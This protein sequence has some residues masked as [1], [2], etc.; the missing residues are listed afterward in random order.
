MTL[1]RALAML[2]LLV[3]L[4]ARVSDAMTVLPLDLAA[5]TEG[6]GTIFVGRVTRV[7]PGI[8][9]RGIP[10]V[11][12][13]FAIEESLKGERGHTLTMKQLGTPLG[14]STA[15]PSVPRF[16]PGELV[17]LFVHAPSALGFA[18]P[19]GLGQG[20]FRVRERAGRRI[21]ENDVANRNLDGAAPPGARSASTPADDLPLETLISR[22]RALVNATP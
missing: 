11:W 9:E 3:A 20:T 16:A 15:L 5:L 10:A 7:D 4:L 8:D 21:V 6:A 2:A 17:V 18:S 13:T 12:T 19:V 22:V 1:R 14:P